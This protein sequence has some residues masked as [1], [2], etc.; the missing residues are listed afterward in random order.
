M[1]MAVAVAT[2]GLL[3]ASQLAVA[4]S[5]QADSQALTGAAT[6]RTVS[7]RTVTDAAALARVLKAGYT[8]KSC[9]KKKSNTLYLQRL[10]V[11]VNDTW[12]Y[13]ATLDKRI[14]GTLT[15]RS[16]LTGKPTSSG[17]RKVSVTVSLNKIKTA[18][19]VNGSTKITLSLPCKGKGC[20]S[21]KPR[22]STV[23]SW[24]KHPSK[25]FVFTAPTPKTASKIASGKFRL[26]LKI[27]HATTSQKVTTYRCDGVKYL[28]Y[29]S[30]CVFSSAK[31]IL[32]YSRSS[33][34]DEVGA[35]S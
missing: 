14:V 5:A 11:C 22:T 24:R 27:G 13:E 15:M 33:T 8:Q 4:G 25:K 19:T 16:T 9:K 21:P 20:S 10:T 17:S 28:H 31:P 12:Q 34:I 32:I 26:K 6:T 18:G 29:K 1:A 3:V 2:G 35:S 30:G 7:T 23:S